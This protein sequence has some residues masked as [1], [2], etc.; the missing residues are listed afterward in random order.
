M[1]VHE[2]VKKYEVL[3]HEVNILRNMVQVEAN[4][5]KLTH[6]MYLIDNMYGVHYLK[7]ELLMFCYVRV[8]EDATNIFRRLPLSEFAPDEQ[9]H[10]RDLHAPYV[11]LCEVILGMEDDVK[12]ALMNRKVYLPE[13]PENLY[14]VDDVTFGGEISIVTNGTLTVSRPLRLLKIHD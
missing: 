9:A 12:A 3:T 6:P 11:A 7:G 14:T 1:N 10:H 8:R 13:H 4:M 5:I 2:L